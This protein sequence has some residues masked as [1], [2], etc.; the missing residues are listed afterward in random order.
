M[1]NYIYCAVHIWLPG[2]FG[3]KITKK[4]TDRSLSAILVCT[5]TYKSI[6]R[7]E[8]ASEWGEDGVG[9]N[10]T[11]LLEG[12]VIWSKGPRQ[13]DLAQGRHKVGAPEEQEDVVE[14]EQD[15]I[16]VVEGL[17]AV[18][19]KQ[20]LCIWTLSSDVGCVECLVKERRS[21]PQGYW[22]ICTRFSITTNIQFKF[23]FQTAGGAA[24]QKL[25]PFFKKHT[26]K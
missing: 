3:S 8:G 22:M 12:P 13:S 2:L 17:S 9:G 25:C 14:L 7:P 24:K 5:Y 16:L 4:K 15:E 19:G 11:R 1:H 10:I 26:D 6:F 20:T 23:S 18:E 21:A